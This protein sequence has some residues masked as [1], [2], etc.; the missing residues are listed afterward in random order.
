MAAAL[1]ALEDELA[2]AR[3]QELLQQPRRRHV[4]E[5]GDAH[6]LQRGGLRGTPARD[7]RVGRADLP[8]DLQ[9]GGLDLLGGEAEDADAPGCVAERVPGLFQHGAGLLGA[10]QRERDEGKPALAAHLGGERG[11]V[12][13]PGH[14][15]LGDGQFASEGAAARAVGAE[16]GTRAP[17][18]VESGAR[19]LQRV[20]DGVPY[21]P[22]RRVD[23]APALLETGGEE[24]VLTDLGGGC[25]LLGTPAPYD[26]AA[27]LHGGLGAVEP[28]EQRGDPGGQF[29]LGLGEQ[30]ELGV[31]DDTGAAA[32]DDGRRG[33][34][35]RAA[36]GPDR[37]VQLVVA[38]ELLEQYEGAQFAHGTARLVAPGDQPLCPGRGGP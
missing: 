20:E 10:G 16:R 19:A 17:R 24:A 21:A 29:G 22:H 28:G 26:S 32:R 14:R 34:R 38:E 15:P 31:Q 6:L 5:G 3:F 18:R 13:H 37:K 11:L 4:Q 30:G 35:A 36:A 1:G 2:R 33:V 9:L 7:D 12:A 27:V 23:G 25:A 8:D